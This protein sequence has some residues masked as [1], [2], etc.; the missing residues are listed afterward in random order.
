MKK[1]EILEKID[2]KEIDSLCN[3]TINIEAGFTQFEKNHNFG[4]NYSLKVS[5]RKPVINIFKINS[6]NNILCKTEKITENNYRCVFM[7]VNHDEKDK[8]IILYSY[9][10]NQLMI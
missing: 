3:I 2:N 10:L 6:D 1:D 7:A 8:D 5:L 9:I 4:A